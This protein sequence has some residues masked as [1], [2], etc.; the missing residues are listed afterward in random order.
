MRTP[1]E[2]PLGLPFTVDTWGPS[3]RHRC[4]R[5]ITHA[6]TDHIAGAWAGPGDTVYATQ[7][8]MRLALERYPQLERVKFVEMEVGKRWV[9]DDPDG[10]FSV[11]AYDANHCAG[12]VMLLFEGPFGTILHTGDCRLTSHCV[13]KL[14]LKLEANLC[15][16]D[17][18]YLDLTFPKFLEFPSKESA[19]QQVIACISK[20][21]RAPFIYLG[22]QRLGQEDILKEV[23]RSFRSKIYVDKGLYLD[24]FNTL[25]HTVP[26]IITDD[27]TGRFQVLPVRSE[28]LNKIAAE[29]LEEARASDQPEPLFIRPS[30]WRYSNAYAQNRKPSLT[31]AEQDGNVWRV[32][33]SNHSSSNELEQAL[34]LLQPQWVIST[35]PPNF[36]SELSYVRR[37]YLSH[38]TQGH[39]Q[40]SICF[41]TT[42]RGKE[43]YEY[44]IRGIPSRGQRSPRVVQIE[45]TWVDH[46]TFGLSMGVNGYTISKH[47]INM[48]GK[49]II[50]E[51][52]DAHFLKH[53]L[54]SELGKMLQGPSPC[55]ESISNYLSEPNQGFKLENMDAVLVPLLNSKTWYLLVANFWKRRFEVLSPMGCTDELITQAQSIV[56]NFREDFHSAYP[57][58]HSV[59]IKDMDITFHT[60]SNSD[61]ESDSGIFIMKALDL[62]DGEKHIFFNDSDAE[63]LRE[64]LA[65]YLLH[66]K[67]NEMPH[68]H[69]QGLVGP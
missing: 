19:I 64:H 30:A 26:E 48:M 61:N 63:G 43:D 7:L 38:T 18:V 53:V 68:R 50:S 39:A 28:E 40:S 11:T 46:R 27:P 52:R 67:Y 57:Q 62:Y 16:L 20:H 32:C 5:F 65:L 35:T 51:Q 29:K 54:H 44:F 13:Q 9:V 66:H 21:S 17:T 33:F 1:P 10:A 22:C 3:R 37:R 58:L 4:H 2:M 69:V 59:K 55:R 41:R 24:C 45:E 36:A 60:I 42:S 56:C 23:S 31:E 47:V 49:A 25:S 14:L 12:A 6:H 8:T 15:R 34:Q